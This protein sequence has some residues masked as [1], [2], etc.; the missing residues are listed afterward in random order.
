MG[1][2]HLKNKILGLMENSSFERIQAE[3]DGLPVRDVIHALFSA[4]CRSNDTVHW[5]G[6]RCMGL[7]VAQLADENME[8]ARIIMRRLLWSLNDESGGIGWGAPESLAEI[9]FRHEGLAGEYIHMLVSYM[10]ED[11][12][13]LFQDGNYL[14]H[15]TLQRGLLWGVGRL[16]EKR[17]QMLVELGAPSDLLPYL[18]SADANVRGLAVRALGL[19]RAEGSLEAISALLDDTGKVSFFDGERMR[20]A[21]LGEVALEATRNI[22]AAMEE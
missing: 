12:N 19:L 3:L 15:E 2:R 13:E 18:K 5:N 11:G 4:I 9:M 14:E 17:P 21:T 20:M 16:A 8:D 10:R 7:S 22:H 6:V 1:G